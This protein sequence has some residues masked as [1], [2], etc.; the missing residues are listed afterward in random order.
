MTD[1]AAAG[2]TSA[3]RLAITS[4]CG[5]HLLSLAPLF[6]ISLC[7]HAFQVIVCAPAHPLSSPPPSPLPYNPPPFLSSHPRLSPPLFFLYPT[8]AELA[9]IALLL[10]ALSLA[11]PA[12]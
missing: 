2:G 10:S 1:V 4:A 12:R 8:I 6:L 11:P 9:V 5:A 7:L 3:R